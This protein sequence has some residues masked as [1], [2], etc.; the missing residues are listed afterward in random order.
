MNLVQDVFKVLFTTCVVIWLPIA[1]TQAQPQSVGQPLVKL[2][3]LVTDVSS[4][5]IDDL[6]EEEFRVFDND[7]PQVISYFSTE[8]LPLLC[9]IVMDNSGSFKNVLKPAVNAA[10]TIINQN[11]ASDET[12]L[13]RFIDSR[14]IE[15]V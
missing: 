6:K 15:T 4:R 7:V 14:K 8:E 2:N 11:K 13:I 9:G 10:K 3:V 5:P 1:I 12:L